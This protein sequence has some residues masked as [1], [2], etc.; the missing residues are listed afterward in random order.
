MFK[1]GSHWPL[2]SREVLVQQV[3]FA[4]SIFTITDPHDMCANIAAPL[5]GGSRTSIYLLA[6]TCKV[7]HSWLIDH[8]SQVLPGPHQPSCGIHGI[9]RPFR[10]AASS[11]SGANNRLNSCNVFR[12][13]QLPRAVPRRV[14][15]WI[16]QLSFSFSQC[17]PSVGL[18]ETTINNHAPFLK[19]FDL[20][21]W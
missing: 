21:A 3:L 17:L 16:E 13:D 2:L 12:Q 6:A 1:S 10:P 15:F 4:S 5:C 11:S 20:C 7:W 8:F 14:F 19:F 18:C 9:S